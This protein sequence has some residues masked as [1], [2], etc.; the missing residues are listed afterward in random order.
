MQHVSSTMAKNGTASQ[1]KVENLIGSSNVT[2]EVEIPLKKSSYYRL[3]LLILVAALIELVISEYLLTQHQWTSIHL[4][5]TSSGGT[6]TDRRAIQFLNNLVRFK[7]AKGL[8]NLRR[9]AMASAPRNRTIAYMLEHVGL[10]ATPDLL[11]QF[12]PLE[13]ISALYGDDVIIPG[14][15]ET[16]EAYRNAVPLEDRHTGPA[17]MFN[18]G[19]NLLYTLLMENCQL[20]NHRFGIIWQVPWGKH[21]PLSWK[22][23]NFPKHWLSVEHDD[24]LAMVVIKDPYTWLRSM[25]RESYNAKWPRSPY[26]C[27]NVIKTEL[28]E[29]VRE[30]QSLDMGQPVPV[31][32]KY[33]ASHITN[34]TNLIALWNDW[35]GAYWKD[36]GPRLFIRYEDMLFRPYETT[37]QL[38]TCIGGNF[39]YQGT[40]KYVTRSAKGERGSHRGSSDLVSALL[41]YSNSTERI[42]GFTQAD[43]KVAASD[44]NKLLLDTFHYPIPPIHS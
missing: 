35:Y 28:D 22:H 9:S 27:P 44:L 20:P 21:T 42:H 29:H 33:N 24:T 15:K 36:N 38:C 5:D 3:I 10:N 2:N 32:I 4:R 17:G 16:C 7:N 23:R 13:E 34:H 11:E 8:P 39:T 40:F 12:P 18:S 41:R 25:C 37:N 43:L 1:R 14:L 19:T 6:P 31:Y 30:L 26:H